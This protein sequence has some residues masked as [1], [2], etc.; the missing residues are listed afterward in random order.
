MRHG[1]LSATVQ[2]MKTQRL[3]RMASAAAAVAVT[4]IVGISG[5]ASA[6]SGS[7]KEAQPLDRVEKIDLDEVEVS[8]NVPFEVLDAATKI[9]MLHDPVS[10]EWDDDQDLLTIW[11]NPED[12]LAEINADIERIGVVGIRAASAAYSLADIEAASRQVIVSGLGGADVSW[13]GPASDG[14]GLSVGLEEAPS[15]QTRSSQVL[16]VP[17]VDVTVSGTV[18]P[19]SRNYDLSPYSAGADMSKAH[20]TPGYLNLCTTGFGVWDYYYGSF[21]TI[22]LTADHCLQASSSSVWNTGWSPTNPTVG[23]QIGSGGSLIDIGQIRGQEYSGYM[24]Y[25]NNN[26]NSAVAVSGYVTSVV[27]AQYHYSGARSGVIYNNNA[28]TINATI[29]YGG[30]MV[31]EG[32]TVTQQMSS[33]PAAGPG[34]SG[35]PVF[36]LDSNGYVYAAGIISGISGERID[37]YGDQGRLC[38]A[39]AIFADISDYFVWHPTAEILTP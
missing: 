10:M 39:T 14:S 28:T 18:E 36:A 27:G 23:T 22:L 1:P 29:N 38:S 26:S 32:L 20:N 6:E 19:V 7:S 33:G 24:Y 25:G 2:T 11:A 31:Y 13:A 15:I 12:S 4:A 9:R 17:I 16:G 5:Q 35:G 37:C 21:Q 34:D 30:G 8:S 3:A